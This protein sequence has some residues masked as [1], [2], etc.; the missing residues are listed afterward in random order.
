MSEQIPDLID[1]IVSAPDLQR[2]EEITNVIISQDEDDIA[3]LLE[4]FHMSSA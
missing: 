4:S 1:E 2:V 3:H